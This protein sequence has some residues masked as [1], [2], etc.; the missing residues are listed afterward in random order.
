MF[1]TPTREHRTG[2]RPISPACAGATKL[3]ALARPVLVRSR[4]T[5][6]SM[7]PTMVWGLSDAITPGLVRVVPRSIEDLVPLVPRAWEP[8][9]APATPAKLLPT[10][11]TSFTTPDAAH[12]TPVAPFAPRRKPA[13]RRMPVAPFAHAPVAPFAHHAPVVPTRR[14]Q[15]ERRPPRHLPRGSKYPGGGQAQATSPP[16]KLFFEDTTDEAAGRAL[17]ALAVYA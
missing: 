1:Q 9:R 11:M 17:M 12:H 8:T 2:Y 16:R 7:A 13:A 14:G 3:V 5:T 10:A 15:R 4:A 6:P